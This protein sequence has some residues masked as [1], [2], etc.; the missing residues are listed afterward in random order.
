MLL[1]GSE[2]Y[3]DFFGISELE[4]RDIAEDHRRYAFL[5]GN[6]ARTDAEDAEMSAL[7]TKLQRLGLDPGWEPVARSPS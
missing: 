1:T 5:V 6:P 2:L 7:R 3:R 4:P